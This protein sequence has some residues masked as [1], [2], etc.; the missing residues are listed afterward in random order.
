[1]RSLI[2]LLLL[3]P[4]CVN[5]FADASERSVQLPEEYLDRLETLRQE[6]AQDPME[7]DPYGGWINAPKTLKNAPVSGFFQVAKLAGS[8]W[9]ITPDGHPFVSKGVTDVNWL[10]ATLSEGPFHDIIVQKY[11][12]EQ[13]WADAA[14]NR[15]LEWGYNTVGPWSSGSMASQMT[16][17]SIILDMAGGNGP[18]HPNSVVTDYWDPAFVKHCAA[19]AHERAA[20]YE[21][22]VSFVSEVN[23]RVEAWHAQ[24]GEEL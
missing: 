5:L 21:P 16:H 12:T 15:L 4:L 14:R 11:G 19:M 7:L 3:A 1:M 17:A 22:F 2:L 20:P 8:W 23:R 18:R 24:A 13:A 9:F 10:G 6:K